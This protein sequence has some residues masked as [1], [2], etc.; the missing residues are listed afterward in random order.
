MVVFCSSTWILNMAVVVTLT[1]NRLPEIIRKLPVE[2]RQIVQ[3][4]VFDIEG[5]IKIDMASAKSGQM[6]GDHQASAPGEAPAVDTSALINSIQTEVNGSEGEVYTNA[7]YAVHLEYG[8]P[9][10][11]LEPRPFMTPA[12][13]AA[14]P[15][16]MRKMKS[17]ESRL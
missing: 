17:L 8:A 12:A 10:N 4:T 16:F 7:E 2:T 14:R 15:E 1:H 13:E 3:E 5:R 11:N 6:Y 9:M